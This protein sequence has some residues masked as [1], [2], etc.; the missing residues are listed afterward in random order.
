M[1]LTDN[2]V[3]AWMLFSKTTFYSGESITFDIIIKNISEEPIDLVLSDALYDN[4]NFEVRT[5]QNQVVDK[6]DFWQILIRD[7]QLGSNDDLN[8][9]TLTLFPDEQYAKTIHLNEFYQLNEEGGYIIRA[10]FYPSPRFSHEVNPIAVSTAQ[11]NI[12]ESDQVMAAD[13]IRA[14]QLQE[15]EELVLTPQDTIEFM[16]R[17]KMMGDWD[18]YFKYI[19]LNRLIQSNDFI[20]Y[21]ER[22]LSRPP[23]ERPY[24]I[25]E[26][27]QYLK[28]YLS[29][30]I[31]SFEIFRTVIEP[32][33]ALV[34]C[35]IH[36]SF[37][38]NYELR[39]VRLTREY[40]FKLYKKNNRWFVYSFTV[41]AQ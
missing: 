18:N 33:L 1:A 41:R 26:F 21:Q 35:D 17:S 40:T 31:E 29:E 12:R 7:A 28:T 16:L 27:K 8:Y 36:Y 38:A 25:D 13:R 32:D 6:K 2:Q 19:D 10:D 11:I 39:Q 22:Y 15:E 34:Y 30:D 5:L 37:V 9:R 24:V 3:T 4:F 23:S 20:E 14:I